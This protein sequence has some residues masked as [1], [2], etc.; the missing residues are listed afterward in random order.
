MAGTCPTNSS[1]EAFWGTSHRV[2]P[3]NSDQFEHV[4]IAVGTKLWCLWLDFEAKMASS[5]DGTCPCDLLRW[6]VAG[7]SPLVCADLYEPTDNCLQLENISPQGGGRNFFN[8]VTTIHRE[9][10]LGEWRCM[11]WTCL[12]H[13]DHYIE[14]AKDEEDLISV[15]RWLMV[16]SLTSKV[17]LYNGRH[18][19]R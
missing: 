11:W 8:G 15:Y 12:A 13:V 10:Y 17:N 5:H 2:L 7:T 18:L 6:L 19:I 1:H 3:K 4:E 16:K 9:K 14:R